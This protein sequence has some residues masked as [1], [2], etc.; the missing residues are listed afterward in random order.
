MSLGFN[1]L[2]FLVPNFYTLQYENYSSLWIESAK[3]I[4]ISR[5]QKNVDIRVDV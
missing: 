2:G 4:H 3:P 5:L 1:S